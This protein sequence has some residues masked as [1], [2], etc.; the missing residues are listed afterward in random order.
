MGVVI[1]LKHT[2]DAID[3]AAEKALEQIEKK[4]YT[5][6]FKR[7]FNISNVLC[8]GIA[9]KGKSCEVSFKEITL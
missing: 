5:E 3:K 9:F 7:E 2:D 6:I 4:D 8:F 1:E